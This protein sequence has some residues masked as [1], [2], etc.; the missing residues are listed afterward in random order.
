M[1]ACIDYDGGVSAIDSGYVRPM[2]A[3]IHLVVEK[4]RAALVDT[5]TNFS[6]PGLLEAMAA[7]GVAP[8]Q[9]DW[10][11]LTHVHLDHAGGA[12]LLMAQCPNA[13]LTV[14]PRG[15]RHMA[16][17]A[18]LVAGTVE[19]YGEQQARAKYGEIVPVPANR[20]VETP[21][22]ASV[23][24]GEREF[25]FLDTPG[26]ARH[27]VC[28]VDGGTGHVFAGDTFGLSY[29]ELDVE[30]RQFIF[31]STTPVQ[32]DPPLLHRSIERLLALRPGAIHVT[33]FGQVREVQRL[34]EDLRR[35]VDA[36]ASL[37]QRWRDA[38]AD[39]HRRLVDGLREM[40]LS[41]GRRQQWALPQ[42]EVLRLF[43]DDLELNAAGLEAWLD[44]TT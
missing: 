14:H 20:I 27:H 15:A 34:G 41:E 38:G 43:A 35:L 11:M 16:D 18:R 24:L 10:V 30:G 12:G 2:L 29:R 31:P 28:I 42:A 5:G 17:P 23:R 32:F 8:E 37:A 4:D 7:R 36:H 19:V 26:H 25:R 22:G 1:V 44:A 39:R 33:H 40:L 21:D 3:A 6:V 13:R 9:V